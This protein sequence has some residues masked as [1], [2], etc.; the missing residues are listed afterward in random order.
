M[1]GRSPSC[2]RKPGVVHD[3]NDF[4]IGA[5]EQLE[6]SFLAISPNI[7]MPALVDLETSDGG[8]LWSSNFSAI[9]Q[10]LS[11]KFGAFYSV[12]ESAVTGVEPWAEKPERTNF[13]TDKQAQVHLLGPSCWHS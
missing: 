9:L 5:G 10:Y 1:A 4:D 2:S 3:V 7:R 11:R 6:P 8:P 13:A 12:E